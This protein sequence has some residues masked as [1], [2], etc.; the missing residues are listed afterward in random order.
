MPEAPSN[1]DSDCQAHGI[2]GTIAGVI[3]TLMSNEAIKEIL[4]FNIQL[5]KNLR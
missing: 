5:I 3:G 2:I 1:D 4:S